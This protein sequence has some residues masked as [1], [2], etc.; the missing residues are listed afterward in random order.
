MSSNKVIVKMEVDCVTKR[1]GS[2]E[3]T[4]FWKK[5]K[6]VLKTLSTSSRTLNIN[7]TKVSQKNL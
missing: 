4:S 1:D 5:Y 6:N 2:L 3:E 7:P